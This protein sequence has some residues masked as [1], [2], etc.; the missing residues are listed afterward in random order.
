MRFA[1]WIIVAVL[2]AGPG[3]AYYSF[4]GATI[5]SHLSTIAIPLAVDNSVS[6]VTD[7]DERLTQL[8]VERFVNQTR[9]ALE[10]GEPDADAVLI[11]RIESYRNVPTSVSGDEVAETNRV[12]IGVA[13]EYVDQV[14]DEVLL[15]QSFSGFAEYDPNEGFDEERA[16]AIR[17]LENVTEDI[18][19]RATSNW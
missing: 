7:L 13:V 9:L 8:L 15:Q 19:N 3:C 12:T 16:A 11:A 1:P 14:N 4:T 5:P 17:A 10:P 18:F 6:T 2:L